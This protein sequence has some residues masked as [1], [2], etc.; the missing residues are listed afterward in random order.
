MKFS[1]SL[2]DKRPFG[3]QMLRVRRVDNAGIPTALPAYKR[4]LRKVSVRM[5]KIRESAV[6]MAMHGSGS[7]C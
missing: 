2:S 1:E 5:E 4:Q 6:K 7:L 3:R